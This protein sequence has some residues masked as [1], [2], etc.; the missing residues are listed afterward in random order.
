VLTRL[1]PFYFCAY[2]LL[3]RHRAQPPKVNLKTTGAGTVRFNPNLYDSGKVCLSL[4]GT[5]R[6]EQG[7]SWN[8]DTSTFLQVAVSI[9][10]LIFVPQPYFNEVCVCMCVNSRFGKCAMCVSVAQYLMS[11]RHMLCRCYVVDFKVSTFFLDL[12]FF[13]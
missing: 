5:W 12:E 4:L 8:A 1:L 10:A 11:G 3:V 13:M 9:Q 2:H 7:E 6:G